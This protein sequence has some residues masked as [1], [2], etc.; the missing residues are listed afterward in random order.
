MSKGKKKK[1]KQP[2]KREHPVRNTILAIVLPVAA[3]LIAAF[4]V[5]ISVFYGAVR[6]SVTV[7]LGEETPEA[8]A[9]LRRDGDEAAYE[10]APEPVYRKAGDYR[11]KVL[12]RG[13]A[14]P[15]VLRVRDTAAPTAEAVEQTV[16]LGQPVTPDRLIRDLEDEG[17]V[18]V[19]FGTAP[20]F[21][22]VG[23]Y[24]AV[25]LLEDE[26]GNRSKVS[27]PVHV[28]AALDELILEAGSPVP[29]ADDLLL[30]PYTEAEISPIT[31]K[32][33]REPGEYTI[34]VAA[35]GTE[36]ETRL[37]IRDTIP[38]TGR[39][40]TQILAP[41]S[42]IRPDMFV[43]DIFDETSVAV[44][45]AAQ[46]DPDSLEPQTVALTLR[47][48]GGNV[49]TVYST[50]LFTNAE[51]KVIEARNMGLSVKELLEEGTY[52]EASL[53]MQFI[54][55]EIGQHVLAVT[56]DGVRNIALID[57]RDT[58]PP[59][60][61]VMR[62]QWY[63]GTPIAAEGLAFAED[64]TEATLDYLKEPDWNR[65]KQEVTLVS[66]DTS[67]NRT[68]KTFTLTLI[69]DTEPPELYGVRDLFC[70]VDEA[71]TFLADVFA[72]D[73]CDGDVEVTA[74]ASA[75]DI[76]RIGSYTIVYYA[77]DARGNTAYKK[78]TVRVVT[79]RVEEDRAQ[80]VADKIMAKIV[81]DDMTLAE[82]IEAIYNYVYE[83]VHY[84][85]TSNKQDWRSEAVR[86]LTT[87]R[88]DCFTS[89]AAARLLLEQTDA[90]IRSVT[91][92][93][94]NSHHYWLLVN[95][96]TGWY[97]FDACRAWT[98]KFR[99]FMWTDAQTRRHSRSY[100]NYDPSLYPPVATEPYN[101]GK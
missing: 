29:T 55:D 68:E 57:V 4:F 87:G 73:D 90:E 31:E 93:S 11:L 75:V 7:E 39:G 63:L 23:D 17:L 84:V 48:R 3:I 28:R 96:G 41:G 88:G 69:P 92:L 22:A 15:V 59:A 52:T 100:W 89:Y 47:D 67:G 82:Q 14:V 40:N 38:P 53:D 42:K 32:M 13:R 65:D 50:L 33:M 70:Y 74:D 10:T 19:S 95:I 79:S 97:H 24:D 98:G 101:G 49:A 18:K 30:I 21:S 72:W 51:P 94:A 80:E 62:S 9:F 43:T 35:D 86:G 77:T 5:L 44:T 60:V 91:R 36:S 27:V 54:P 26:S 76:S 2:Q 56:V 12:Y 1:N 16:P 25:V 99:C 66:V 37:I 58:T 64:V 45:F 46:P 78:A 6:R 81:T 34:T 85:A 83:N 71:A 8:T 20:D 61:T